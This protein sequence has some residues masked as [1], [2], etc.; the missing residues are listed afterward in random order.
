MCILCLKKNFLLLTIYIIN[1]LK[2]VWEM[3]L[4]DCLINF[5]HEMTSHLVKTD[6]RQ[7]C[8]ASCTTKQ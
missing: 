3:L 2:P 1:F 6:P 8:F 7:K 4:K 5:F